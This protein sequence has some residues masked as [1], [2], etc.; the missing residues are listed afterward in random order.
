[1]VS[2][3]K[4]AE[5]LE[6][7]RPVLRD[8]TSFLPPPAKATKLGH[9]RYRYEDLSTFWLKLGF[10]PSELSPSPPFLKEGVGD[11]PKGKTVG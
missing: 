2:I 6:V 4:A 3:S 10:T 8:L 1:L 5:L 11:Q 9:P 7:S